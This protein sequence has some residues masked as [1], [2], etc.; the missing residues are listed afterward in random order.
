[1]QICDNINSGKIINK[2][3]NRW[4]EIKDEDAYKKWSNELCG[5][6]FGTYNTNTILDVIGNFNPIRGY[7]LNSYLQEVKKVLE[8]S[9]SLR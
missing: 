8:S 9:D 4:F 5:L 2:N 3:F 7:L 6:R 1:M